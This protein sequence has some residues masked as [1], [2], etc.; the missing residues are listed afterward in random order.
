MASAKISQKVFPI[1][2]NLLLWLSKKD[3]QGEKKSPKNFIWTHKIQYP[4][5]DE[6]ISAK[7]RKNFGSLS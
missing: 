6:K 4:T 1:K 3:E 2:A 7:Q 5:N